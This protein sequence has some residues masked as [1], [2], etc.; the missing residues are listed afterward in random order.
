MTE[1]TKLLDKVA[2]AR[3]QTAFMAYVLDNYGPGCVLA[4][5][6]WHAPKLFRAALHAIEQERPRSAP[7]DGKERRSPF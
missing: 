5:P 7:W 3:A 6:A 2:E 4:D 1:K